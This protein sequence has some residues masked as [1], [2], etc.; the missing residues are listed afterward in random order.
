MTT[1]YMKLNKIE[2]IKQSMMEI[3]SETTQEH[4]ETLNET[5]RNRTNNR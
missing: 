3:E 1:L 4:D 2:H 5:K